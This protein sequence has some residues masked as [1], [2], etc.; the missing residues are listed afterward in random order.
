MLVVVVLGMTGGARAAEGEPPLRG[1]ELAFRSGILIPAG[2]VQTYTSTEPPGAGP[3]SISNWFKAQFPLWLDVGYRFDRWFVGVYGQY[4]FGIPALC[5]GP[6]CRDAGSGG[7]GPA[8]SRSSECA[9]D[10]QR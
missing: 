2:D 8:V 6:G 4:A 5:S 7:V 1:F 3:D 9:A 10:V